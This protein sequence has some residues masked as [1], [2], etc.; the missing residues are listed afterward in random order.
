VQRLRGFFHLCVKQHLSYLFQSTKKVMKHGNFRLVFALLAATV[1]FLT[2][3]AQAQETTKDFDLTNFDRLEM[4]SAFDI[5]VSKGNFDVKVAGRRKDVDE[6]TADVSGGKL[7]IRYKDGNSWRKNREKI[8]ITVSMPTIKGVDFSGASRSRVSGFSGLGNFDMEIS[9]AS[10][11][12]IEIDANR[13]VVNVSGASS[14][15]MIGKASKMEGEISGATTFKAYD[16]PVNE[17]YLNVSGASSA[18]IHANS[19]MEIEASGASS[20][21]YKGT[22]SVRSNTSGASSIKSDS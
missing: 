17:A 21:R 9:G 11:S 3:E 10:K 19:K 13:V 6:L 22:A 20:V 16:F 12:D 18:R 14:V 8:T 15:I 2:G 1:L 5:T 7:R 4:G